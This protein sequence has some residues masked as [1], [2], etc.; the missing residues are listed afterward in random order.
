MDFKLTGEQVNVAELLKVAQAVKEEFEAN[1]SS[2]IKIA[3]S[4]PT[5]STAKVSKPTKEN[6][7]KVTKKRAVPKAQINQ[8]TIPEII[9]NKKSISAEAHNGNTAIKSDAKSARSQ[10]QSLPYTEPKTAEEYEMCISSDSDEDIQQLS[11]QKCNYSSNATVPTGKLLPGQSLPLATPS[12]NPLQAI[13]TPKAA[14]KNEPLKPSKEASLKSP[15]AKPTPVFILESE[16]CDFN[17]LNAILKDLLGDT[18]ITRSNKNGFRVN[19]YNMESQKKLLDYLKVNQSKIGSHTFQ[20]MQ[21]RG[22]RA[23][24]RHLHKATPLNWIR[25]ELTKLGF[26]IRFLDAM[27]NRFNKDPL[28]L[29]EVELEKCDKTVI[30]A[31]LQLN[32]LGNQQI[33]VEK[34]YRQEVAQ[35]FRCQ[36]FGH[37][38]NY[39]SRPYVCVKCGDSHPSS[40]CTKHKDSKGRCANCKGDHTAN[41]RG[42]PAYKAAVK[43]RNWPSPLTNIQIPLKNQDSNPEHPP[44]TSTPSAYTATANQAPRK[45]LK[46]PQN[47]SSQTQNFM[48]KTYAA[49]AASSLP[50]RKRAAMQTNVKQGK[51]QPRSQ[52]LPQSRQ[53]QK[54]AQYN[55]QQESHQSAAPH[56]QYE[57]SPL[58]A[59][60]N[61]SESL[62]LI[63]HKVDQIADSLAHSQEMMQSKFIA[64]SKAIADNLNNLT[65][66]IHALTHLITNLMQKLSTSEA[67]ASTK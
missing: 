17:S 43:L 57:L 28:H 66:S 42:C 36:S 56:V 37:T 13:D 18:Y 60:A 34:M 59:A 45:P 65:T 44:S 21:E 51:Q 6:T 31:F 27:K 67:Q 26:H 47:L 1:M 62:L 16:Y 61:K 10:K 11:T 38:K 52:P 19:C 33:A 9:K 29:F 50:T 35:C 54:P 30:N 20:N 63:T 41:Y 32:K 12:S 24:I 58:S 14:S 39:C 25:D 46:I 40:E 3:P 7:S 49:V 15:A 48:K 2:W 23:V 22:F 64:T 5:N 8:L 53:L 55:L 4:T